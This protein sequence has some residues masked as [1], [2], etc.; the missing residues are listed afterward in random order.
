V[1]PLQCFEL[2]HEAFQLRLGGFI[3]VRVPHELRDARERRNLTFV[4]ASHEL[5]QRLPDFHAGLLVLE[6]REG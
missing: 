3:E 4:P 1:A 5:H 6:E 2:T